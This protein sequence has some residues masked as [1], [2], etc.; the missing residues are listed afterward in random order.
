ML[1]YKMLIIIKLITLTMIIIVKISIL[2]HIFM[3]WCK[4]F[5]IHIYIF[6]YSHLNL[7]LIG[8]L[9]LFSFCRIEAGII[10]NSAQ[11]HS[12]DSQCLTEYFAW[13]YLIK[14]IRPKLT[15]KEL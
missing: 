7:T 4:L 6:L 9:L 13:S 8:E 11:G 2:E 15:F 12:G 3:C 5:C 1:A 14:Q 10:Y